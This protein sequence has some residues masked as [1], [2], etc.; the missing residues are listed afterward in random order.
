[1]AE[2]LKDDKISEIMQHFK[3]SVDA[4]GM[5]RDEM[6]DDLRMLNGENIW[7]S[8]IQADRE[9]D[10]RPCLNI[11]KLPQF[12][13]QVVGDLL[14]NRPRLSIRPVDSEADPD[15]AR[16]LGGMIRNIENISDADTVIDTAVNS[17]TACGLGAWRIV[18]D[19]V[20]NESFDQEILYRRIKNPFTCWPDPMAQE[21]NYSDGKFFIITEKVP[22]EQFKKDYPGKRHQPVPG[23]KDDSGDWFE[24]KNIRIA[25]YFEKEPTN[26]KLYLI[27]YQDE[28]LERAIVDKLP[29]SEERPYKKIDER[30]IEDYKIVHYKVTGAEILDGPNEWPGKYFPIILVMGK[31]LNI[32]NKTVHHGIVRHAKDPL[33]LYNFSR[34]QSAET[35]SLAPKAPYIM[36]QAQVQNHE[37]EWKMAHKR[38]YPYLLYN[39][40]PRS[41]GP[42]QRQIPNIVH[43]G[44]Q[45]EIV[46]ADQE[47]HDTIGLQ[48]ASLGE[49]SNEKSGKAI[50]AR[51]RQGDTAQVSY[52]ANLGRA[53]KYAGKVLV[54]LI[55]K[56]YD[57]ERIVR[58]L[59][60]DDSEE[61]VPINTPFTDNKGI[62]KI[63]DLNVGKYDTVVRI[64]PSYSTMREEAADSMMQFI[65]VVPQAGPII[66]DLIAKNLDWPGADQIQERLQKLLPPGLLESENTPQ[67]GPQGQPPPIGPPAP[68]PDP[69][70]EIKLAQEQEKL[71]GLKLDNIKKSG[72]VDL[73]GL[74]IKLKERELREKRFD[75]TGSK[76]N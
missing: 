23:D 74:D 18:T 35:I 14:I 27:E 45:Q 37:R 62:E 42:P 61:H 32:E 69:T 13:D 50:I 29:D 19:Y 48:E 51:Q 55:P 59:G 28:G 40:D 33:R 24:P 64:G 3:D 71:K 54:D 8:D 17:M 31:E 57:T 25:E 66:G 41:P 67:G 2:K 4:F 76:A 56:I 21:W 46:I 12:H 44:I 53:M 34:S 36:T 65:K 49:R 47:L 75:N 10:G 43:T 6:V 11:N 60:E 52:A 72:D 38:N 20:D 30:D 15:T 58:I 70:I 1:M 7:P 22:V 39:A 63:Y 73:K 26:K 5:P 16:I 9:A 68:P